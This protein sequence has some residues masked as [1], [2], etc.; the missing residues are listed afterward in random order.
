MSAIAVEDRASG[1]H[2]CVASSSRI[3]FSH[4]QSVLQALE[5]SQRGTTTERTDTR[6]MIVQDS[7][8]L[9]KKKV[10]KYRRALLTTV[11]K[12]NGTQNDP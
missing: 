1:C 8:K 10:K 12:L 11:E 2:F 4:I 5:T 6:H 3:S 7:I 9:S